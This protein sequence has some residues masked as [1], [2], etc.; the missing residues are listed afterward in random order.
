MFWKKRRSAEDLREEIA[1]HLAHQADERHGPLLRK[2]ED[3][4]GV[5]IEAARAGR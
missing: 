5:P 1:S 3:E 2:Y 4:L